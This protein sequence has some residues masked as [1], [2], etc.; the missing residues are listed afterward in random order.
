[1]EKRTAP[2]NGK[3]ANDDDGKRQTSKRRRWQMANG[4]RRWQ[5]DLW[6][7]TNGKRQTANKQTSKWTT[8]QKATYKGKNP[9]LLFL[10]FFL[11]KIK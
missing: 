8:M 7:T 10:L 2:A 5:A 1:M 11:N 3:Q 4:K 9:F 6:T